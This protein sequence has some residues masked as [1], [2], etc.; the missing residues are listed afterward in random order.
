MFFSSKTFL[1]N[2]SPLEQFDS[3]SFLIGS[4]VLESVNLYSFYLFETEYSVVERLQNEY[5]SFLGLPIFRE[6]N[7]TLFIVF[8]FSLYI[9]IQT[10][11]KNNMIILQDF[12]HLFFGIFFSLFFPAAFDFVFTTTS[13]LTNDINA[14]DFF[15]SNQN[16]VENIQNSLVDLTYNVSFAWDAL[17]QIN[18]SLFIDENL[19]SFFLAFFLLG[20]SEQDEDED[21]I[22]EEEEADFVDD[23][24]ASLFLTNLGKDIEGNGELLVKVSSIFSFVL[25]NNLM[26]MLPYSDT[27]TSSL[28]LTFWVA[29]SIFVSLLTIMIRKNG[30][31]FFFSLFMPAGCPVPLMFL[32][33]PIEFI[34]YSFRLVSLSVRLFANMMAGHTLLK[35]IVGFSFSM[36]LMGDSM[37]IVNLFPIALLF[38]LTFLEV[39]VALIQAYI[40]TILTCIYLKDIFVGH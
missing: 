7:T 2:F 24:V 3:V 6:N 26:G 4:R 35:V 23:I 37:I 19:I 32:L 30:I 38:V 5:T 36:I 21:F 27:G 13:L 9:L 28:M 15:L 34:S 33:V 31:N 25:M 12:S 20:G 16:S 1:W 22:L 18:F 10:T 29:L 17:P 8:I 11:S 40:F 14:G 39:A